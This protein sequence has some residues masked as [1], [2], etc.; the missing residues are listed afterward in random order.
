M[1]V[2]FRLKAI[3]IIGQRKGFKQRISESSCARKETFDI[4]IPITSRDGDRNIKQ[5]IKITSRPLSR[6]R[7]WN[8]LN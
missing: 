2:N 5:F 6:I 3:Y 4:G 1:F 7:K 8:F